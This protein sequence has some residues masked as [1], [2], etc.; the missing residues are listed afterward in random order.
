MYICATYIYTYVSTLL[1]S[2]YIIIFIILIQKMV[3][4]LGT[5]HFWLYYNAQVEIL[6]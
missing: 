5:V 6:K 4:T 2:L 1:N 3:G